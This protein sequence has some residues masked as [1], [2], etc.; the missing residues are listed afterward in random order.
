MG[1]GFEFSK[2][3]LVFSYGYVEIVSSVVRW[4]VCFVE[5]NKVGVKFW[6]VVFFVYVLFIVGVVDK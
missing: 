4:C 3:V 2:G 6:L 5:C 1:V